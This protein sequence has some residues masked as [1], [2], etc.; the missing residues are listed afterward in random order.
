MAAK[1]ER[2]DGEQT[3]GRRVNWGPPSQIGA[4]NLDRQF[5]LLTHIS[6]PQLRDSD[7]KDMAEESVDLS[8]AYDE[9][10]LFGVHRTCDKTVSIKLFFPDGF[11]KVGVAPARDLCH[12]Q[13]HT[14]DRGVAGTR[15]GGGQGEI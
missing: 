9:A 13:N 14:G 12:R 1:K 8:G 10:G 5:L 2:E 11:K 4:A 6:L 3:A 7:Q 15:G